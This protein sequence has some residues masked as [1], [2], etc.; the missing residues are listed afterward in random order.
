[1][2]VFRCTMLADLTARAESSRSREN[3]PLKTPGAIAATS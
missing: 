3:T 2:M 1:M